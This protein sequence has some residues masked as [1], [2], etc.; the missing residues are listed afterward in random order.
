MTTVMT[1]E[2]GT[3]RSFI[4]PDGNE[5]SLGHLAPFETVFGLKMGD[6]IL[7]IPLWVTFRD[8]CYSRDIS[9]EDSEEAL[10]WIMPA[11]TGEAPRLFC[12]DR[13]TYSHGLPSLLRNLIAG[14]TCYRTNQHGLYF[15]LEKSSRRGARAE[16]GWYMFFSF[17]RNPGREGQLRLSIES[18]HDR[19][20]RPSN[21]RGN[22]SLRF[23]AALKEYLEQRQEL[24]EEIKEEA[25]K[26]KGS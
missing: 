7:E 18:I 9:K 15:R 4:G 25:R 20:T 23:W 6:E 11:K 12:R 5:Y 14:S 22:H 1:I 10:T 2:E 24:F 21:A 19:P 13:W 3:M 16:E 17:A 26:T 8:H